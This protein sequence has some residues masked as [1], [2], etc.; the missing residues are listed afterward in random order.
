MFLL[1]LVVILFVYLSPFILDWKLIL[2]LIAL[3]YLQLWFFGN[4]ILTIRQFKEK[5]RETSFYSHVLNKLGFYPDKKTVR[6]VVDYY[7]PWIIL[8]VALV[9]QIVL[10]HHVVFKIW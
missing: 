5:T 3:Y 8:V 6:I 1:H 9:W 10:G 4:C 2:I 7:V